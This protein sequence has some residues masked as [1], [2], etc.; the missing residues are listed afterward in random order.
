MAEQ[1]L[2]LPHQELVRHRLPE[3]VVAALLSQV[4]SRVINQMLKVARQMAVKVEHLLR[5]EFQLRRAGRNRRLQTHRG[6]RQATRC[7]RRNL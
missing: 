1:L 7:P 5:V 2:E 6:S 3:A 4:G